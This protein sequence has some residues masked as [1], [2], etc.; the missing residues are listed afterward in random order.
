MANLTKMKPYWITFPCTDFYEYDHDNLSKL[1]QIEDDEESRI[2]ELD[3]LI[4]NWPDRDLMPLSKHKMKIIKGL[5]SK[6]NKCK[7]N[8]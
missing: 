8:K 6:K 2:K 1:E 3:S 4:L 7:I 5:G